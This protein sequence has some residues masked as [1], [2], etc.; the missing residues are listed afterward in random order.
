MKTVASHALGSIILLIAISAGTIFFRLGSLPLSGPDEPRYARVAQE[1]QAQGLWITPVLEGKPWLEKP[2]L[3]YWMTIPFLSFFNADER[4]ARS[5]PAVSALVAALAIFWLGSVLWSRLAGLLGASILLTS[6]GFAGFGR[7]ASTDMPF[8]CFFTLAMAFLAAELKNKSGPVLWAYVFLGLSILGKGPVAIVLAAGIALCFW[9]LDDKGIAFS[10]WRIW[11][12]S[13]VAAAICV[14]WFWLV[15][16]E[17]GFAFISTFFL[18]HNVARF[19]TGLHHHSQP[20][21]YFVPVLVALMFPWSGWLFLLFRSPLKQLRRWREWNSGMLFLFCWAFVPVIFFSFSDSKL[22]GYVLPSLPPVAL[23]LGVRFSHLIEENAKKSGEIQ[24]G[25]Y[26][27][28]GFSI[29]FAVAAPIYFRQEYAD[30]VPGLLL[31]IAV[32]TPSLIAFGM[33]RK[34]NRRGIFKIF[35]FQG[36]LAIMIA[37]QFAFPVLGAWHSSR[38]IAARALEARK[39]GEPIATYGFY[40]HSFN[41]YTGYGIA[42]EFYDP[43]SMS[44]FAQR[45]PSSLVA[46]STDGPRTLLSMPGFSFALLGKQGRILLFRISRN[47]VGQ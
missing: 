24:A 5:G 42:G 15:F 10:R 14:P 46:T 18:N 19:V 30:I 20:F 7:S 39:T 32:L 2:P 33:R 6:L 47:N 3:Y 34:E 44:R 17:N 11:T 38:D 27:S 4:A 41:Y 8:T 36:L 26:L 43:E 1:M 9:F 16:R 23:M 12:G 45:Y 40:H 25:I 37:A 31:G 22:A 28:L 13:V 35:A 21:Y 29:A